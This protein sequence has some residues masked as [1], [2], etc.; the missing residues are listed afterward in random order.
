MLFIAHRGLIDGPNSEIE[1][2]PNLIE[3][4]IQKYHAEID[5]R[6]VD[7]EFYLGHDAPQYK[8]DY[9]W[10]VKHS[11]RLW[12]HCK[13]LDTLSHIHSLENKQLNYFFHEN[14]QATLTS[15]GYIWAYPGTKKLPNK[16][17]VLPEIYNDDISDSIGICSDYII[18]YESLIK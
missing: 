18:R 3:S 9:D 4:S 6:V 7:G 2:E 11:S 1:N 8:I 10:I 5:L 12:I 13:D 16:I 14:D 17:S 15:K